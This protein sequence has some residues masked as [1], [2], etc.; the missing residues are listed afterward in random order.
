M[1]FHGIFSYLIRVSAI[2]D[3]TVII[4]SFFFLRNLEYRFETLI[5]FWN[6]LPVELMAIPGECSNYDIAIMIDGIRLLHAELSDLLRIFS[7]GYGQI[8]LGYFVFSY[9]EA[10]CVFYYLVCFELRTTYD[11]PV[12][13][14][15]LLMIVANMENLQNVILTMTIVV[16][17]SRVNE[18]VK[19]KQIF[20]ILI[21]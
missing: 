12:A 17:A 10:L 7:L 8:L 20:N 11:A 3:F 18:K 13:K 5:D 1:D 2:V 15:F 19:T 9:I 14:R 16:S 6:C 4:S 21:L